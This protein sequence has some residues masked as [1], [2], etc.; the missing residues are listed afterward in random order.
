M[1]KNTF[2]GEGVE[3][4]APPLTTPP[5]ETETRRVIAVVCLYPVKRVVDPSG[6]R[7]VLPC[8]DGRMFGHERIRPD[9][10]LANVP[11]EPLPHLHAELVGPGLQISLHSEVHAGPAPVDVVGSDRADPALAVEYADEGR[12]VPFRPFLDGK[13]QRIPKV[14]GRVAELQ[15]TVHR[16]PSVIETEPEE[17]QLKIEILVDLR[18]GTVYVGLIVSLIVVTALVEIPVH[19]LLSDLRQPVFGQNVRGRTSL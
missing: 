7:H 19:E 18:I 5:Y 3:P 9:H 8:D 17:R 2:R 16:H 1:N 4:L 14:F 10:A 12:V 11:H 6:K 15:I 13:R